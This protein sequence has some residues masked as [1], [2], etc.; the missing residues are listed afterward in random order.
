VMPTGLSNLTAVF[1]W[2]ERLEERRRWGIGEARV[3]TQ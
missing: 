2:A 3:T 1:G